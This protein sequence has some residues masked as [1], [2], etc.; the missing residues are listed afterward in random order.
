M[1]ETEMQKVAR[2]KDKENF[3]LAL[4]FKQA[5][6]NGELNSPEKLVMD[7]KRIETNEN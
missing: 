6:L 3:G 5:Y 7:L 2:E 4:F 1:V